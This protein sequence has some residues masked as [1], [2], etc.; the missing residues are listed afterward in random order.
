L[1]VPDIRRICSAPAAG[2]NATYACAG[3]LGC[4]DAL[5]IGD[6]AA[7]PEAGALKLKLTGNLSRA[8]VPIVRFGLPQSG[9][10]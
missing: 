4:G 8:L 1:P 9:S 6:S 7:M 10:S 3:R 2:L 5:H